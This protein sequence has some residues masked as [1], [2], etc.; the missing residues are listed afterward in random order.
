MGTHPGAYSPLIRR[1]CAAAVTVL[2]VMGLTLSAGSAAA[3]LQPKISQVQARVNKLTYREDW[4]IQ[5]YDVMTESLKSA[6]QQLSVVDHAVTKDQAQVQGMHGQIAAI[7]AGE[8]E[9]AALTS[10]ASLVTSSTPQVILNQS[11]MLVHLSADR[12]D[13]LAEFLTSYRELTGAQQLAKRTEQGIAKLRNQLA[14]QKR[15]IESLVKKEQALLATLTAQQQQQVLGGGGGGT[16]GGGYHGPTKTQA[17]KAVWFAY[18][19]LGCPYVYGAT[20]PCNQGFDCSGLTQAAWAY[21]GVA[22]PRDSYGQAT[23]PHVSQ[24]NLQPGDII[25]FAGESHVGIY[26][27][28]GYL[29]DA[30][31][32]GMNV[33]K[34]SLSSPWYAQNYDF[35]VQP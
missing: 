7:A 20:G 8:Y 12:Q 34:V 15:S 23:L 2:T 30:P 9:D 6:Q 18:Q 22:I 27:G 3:A 28:G 26:V 33:E 21:A 25:E 13:Q 14:G 32:P 10:Q 4:L 1:G 16:G 19:Q 29:I 31:Q 17:E 35:A 11:A 24:A 5:R